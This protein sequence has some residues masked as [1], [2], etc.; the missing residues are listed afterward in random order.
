VGGFLDV[1]AVNERGQYSE[2]CEGIVRVETA[3]DNA[4]VVLPEDE[5]FVLF[6]VKGFFEV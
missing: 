1:V 2:Y 3:C 6:E 5:G 4:E